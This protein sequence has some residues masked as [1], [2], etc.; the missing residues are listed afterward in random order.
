MESTAKV[1]KMDGKPQPN[2]TVNIARKGILFKRA[3]ANGNY[4]DVNVSIA[5]EKRP[6][7]PATYSVRV[8]AT[9]TKEAPTDSDI[10]D[11]NLTPL[12]WEKTLKALTESPE[13]E[14]C[15]PPEIKTEFVEVIS[16]TLPTVL[17]E[18]TGVDYCKK[19]LRLLGEVSELIGDKVKLVKNI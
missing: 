8:V 7:S 14:L 2:E 6:F 18:L 3:W 1:L 12:P 19:A 17:R 5:A 9:E 10:K 11:S 13:I 4:G 15:L 16:S